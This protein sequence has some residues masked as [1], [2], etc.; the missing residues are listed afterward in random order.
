MSDLGDAV[1]ALLPVKNGQ[2]YLETL[3][4]KILAMLEKR[5]ELI[6]INDGSSDQSQFIAEKY[7]LIDSR[8]I[9]INT[10]GIGLVASLN[11]GID[12]ARNNWVARFDVDDRYLQN[13]IGEQRKYLS[14]SISVVFSDYQFI[15]Q[16]GRG[17][18]SVYSA[19]LPIP[20]ALSLISSQRTAHP[21]AV[22]N[23]RLLIKS[24]G[25]KTQDFPAEDLA[26][27]LR[28]S[29]FGEIVSVPLPLLY[30]TL[31]RNSI[32][33]K[34]REVQENKKRTLIQGYPS[35]LP[36]QVR[37]IEGFEQTLI[38]YKEISHTPERVLL[39]LRD[40]YLV[41]GSTGKKVPILE[42]V[43]KI[44]FSM[45]C[46]VVYAAVKMFLV[47]FRRRVYRFIYR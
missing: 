39:H 21:S 3:L 17:L 31:S 25:Y 5:D 6:V 43:L 22:I 24:G 41:A 36:L 10:A 33:G 40:L 30:Y 16:K 47:V 27:W 44:G 7:K 46:K 35:W 9:L 37:S 18:G 38:S 29:Q 34:N 8:V 26:L 32:S 15:S 1:S 28:M 2:S 23:R 12:I 45:S 11:L 19:V 42:L 14:E 4:P 13:R 20:T